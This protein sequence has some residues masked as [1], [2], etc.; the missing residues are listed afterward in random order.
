MQH[1]AHAGAGIK[2]KHGKCLREGNTCQD[3]YT[4]KNLHVLGLI[5]PQTLHGPHNE[6]L[7][8]QKFLFL[9][10]QYL[11]GMRDDIHQ[12]RLFW[13]RKSEV[14]RAQGEPYCP[15]GPVMMDMEALGH[16]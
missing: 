13:L 14:C 5:N 8:F 12:T 9:D 6:L 7:C 16:S 4:D 3:V 1:C 10:I 11:R 15:H 2:Q